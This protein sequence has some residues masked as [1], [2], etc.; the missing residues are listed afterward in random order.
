MLTWP[1][2]A[3]SPLPS[4]AQ[5]TSSCASCKVIFSHFRAFSIARTTIP[6]LCFPKHGAFLVCN[7]VSGCVFLASL[8]VL[9]YD[10]ILADLVENLEAAE[11]PFTDQQVAEWALARYRR[12]SELSDNDPLAGL[13]DEQYSQATMPV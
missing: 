2:P 5:L 8:A 11:Q 12:Q 10:T 6:A 3:Q 1:L 9:N 7:R 13:T 4:T